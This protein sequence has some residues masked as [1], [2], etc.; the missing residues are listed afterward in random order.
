MP[1]SAHRDEA[2]ETGH[3]RE[4]RPRSDLLVLCL[5]GFT[6]DVGLGIVSPLL[7]Q[8]MVE[9]SLSAFQIGL[10]VTVFG[11]ARLVTD[12]PLG[13]LLGKINSAKILVAGTLLIVVGSTGIGLAGEYTLLLV[14]R[15][16]MGMGS[17]LCLVT[18]LFT[19]SRDAHPKSRGTAIGA[20]K[21]SQLAGM[22]VSP[23]IGG[24]L[25]GV[26]GWRSA[27]FFC[28]IIGIVTMAMV[29]VLAARGSFVATAGKNK[30]EKVD[31]EPSPGESRW[32]S[33]SWDLVA[34][35]FSTM[36][37]FASAAGFRNSMVPVYGGNQLGIGPA[38]LG[39]LMG[40][41][42]LLR[43]LTTLGSGFASDRFGR[44]A[45]LIPGVILLAM[46]TL[47]FSQAVDLPGFAL[48]LVILSLG[49]FGNSVPTIMVVDAVATGRVGMVISQNRF[50]GD[51]GIL[52]GPV[53]LGWV[54]DSFGF[55]VVTAVTTACL[56]S[57]VPA[58]LLAVRGRRRGNE[59]AA[60]PEPSGGAAS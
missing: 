25:A 46:G 24:V 10:M 20:Y 3:P 35:N 1:E 8:I 50:A 34:I 30:K 13:L 47:G 4:V 2:D 38:A 15:L 16:V 48:C 36:I 43:F 45:I 49:G 22:T 57:I 11:L 37:L 60:R 52:V 59:D 58:V 7:P 29:I 55:P 27:F 54:L 28:A 12:L 44:K 19:V 42:A 31:D 5:L 41:S 18:L 51:I 21:A 33:V 14:A 40:G 39:L 32:K 53:A 17:A 23:A 6:V 26:A 9:F 56:L